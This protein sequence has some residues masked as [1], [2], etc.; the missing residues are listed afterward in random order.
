MRFPLWIIIVFCFLCIG[1]IAFGAFLG[2]YGRRDLKK[3]ERLVDQ[4]GD[5]ERQ[6]AS[7]QERKKLQKDIF[8]VDK[9][10]RLQIHIESDSANLLCQSRGEEL[11][12]VEKMHQMRC[13]VQEKLSEVGEEPQQVIFFIEA[14]H[15]LYSYSDHTL[16]A[17]EASICRYRCASHLLKPSDGSS[18]L[19]TSGR[20]K[21]VVLTVEPAFEFS[22]EELSTHLYRDLP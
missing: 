4:R 8:F 22:A 17:E 5:E 15:A 19:L 18:V 9:G 1:M 21:K 2:N 10:K 14:E 7:H 13:W 3:F 11:A 16:I 12:V 20:A 6:A